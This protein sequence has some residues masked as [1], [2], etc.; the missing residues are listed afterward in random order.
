M[1]HKHV[2]TID[3][4]LRDFRDNDT[5]M[6]GTLLLLSGD[7]CQTLPV[8]PRG[9]PADEIKASLKKSYLWDHVRPYSQLNN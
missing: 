3:R 1:S 7:F 5:V 2:E 9:T 8:I 6:G 4:T